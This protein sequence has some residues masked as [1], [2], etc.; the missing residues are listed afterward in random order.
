M[1]ISHQP[2]D[3]ALDHVLGD[4]EGELG[5][6]LGGKLGSHGVWTC[7]AKVLEY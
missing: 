3:D 2:T 4:E 6:K 7:G 1:R 5:G